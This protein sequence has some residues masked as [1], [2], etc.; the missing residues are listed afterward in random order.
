M[1]VKRWLASVA[2]PSKEVTAFLH[3]AQSSTNHFPI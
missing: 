2:M 3:K 1:A